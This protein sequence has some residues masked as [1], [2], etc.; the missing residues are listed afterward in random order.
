MRRG[1]AIVFLTAAASSAAVAF[2]VVATAPPAA[3]ALEGPI[4]E[5]VAFG[6]YH[7]HSSRSDGTGTVEAIA[8]AAAGAGLQFVVLT[9]HG[10]ATTPPRPPAYVDGVLCIDAVEINTHDGHLVALNLPGAAPYPLAGDARDVIDDLHRLGATAIAAHP[11]SPAP[12]LRWRG[13]ASFDGLEWIN[14]D[15]EWRDNST[16]E[17][18]AATARS[19]VRGPEAIATLF[20]R[21]RFTLQRWD[22]ALRSRRIVGLAALD[23]H[24]RLGA[25]A[26]EMPGVAVAWPSYGTLFRTLA[27]AV[28]LDAPLSGDAAGDARAILASLTAGRTFSIV[29]AIGGPASLEAVAEQAGARAGIGEALAHWDPTAPTRLRAGVPQ[30]PDARLTLS[31]SGQIV[32]GGQGSL[33][34]I[35]PLTPGAYRVEAFLPGSTVPWIVANPIYLGMPEAP[36]DGDALPMRPDID[37]A[38]R[39]DADGP[40]SIERDDRSSATIAVEPSALRFDFSLAG[41][42]AAGQY[43]AIASPVPADVGVDRIAFTARASRPM[44]VSVQVRLPGA[45]AERWRRSVYLDEIPRDIVIRL[46]DM[47]RATRRPSSLRPIVAR[48]QSL[49]IVVDTLNTAPDTSGTV[50]L[51]DVLLGVER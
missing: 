36:E 13:G 31:V 51:R 5:T 20:E 43:A 40:W 3:I 14:A 21:P 16:R 8:R 1:L 35:R 30:A 49:L 37:D 34:V 22:A 41:G 17:L 18:L 6:A 10:D 2:F 42:P 24:A 46:A 48:I 38:V 39:L 44:R 29:R 11:D 15:A 28:I 27:Q 25:D 50:W 19:L 4:P 33:D 23:A 45:D 9:D 32:A 12:S 26:E 47:E 7:V